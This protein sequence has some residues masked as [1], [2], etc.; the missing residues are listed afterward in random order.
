MLQRLI[1]FFLE[2]HLLTNLIFFLVLAGGAA[3]WTILKKEELPDITFDTVRIS[4]SYP[5]AAAEEVEYHVTDPL[6]EALNAIDDIYRITSSTSAGSAVITAELEQGTKNVDRV[7]SEIR[8]EVLATELPEDIRE[9][10]RIRVFKTSRKAV[11]DIGLFNEQHPLLDTVTRQQL[12]NVALELEQQLLARPEL[13]RVDRSGFLQDETHVLVNPEKL[14]ELNIP[15]NRIMNQISLHNVRQPAGSLEAPNQPKVTLYGE[16]RSPKELE[17]L[18]IQ[19]GFEGQVVRLGDIAEVRAGHAE[20][21]SLLK[22]NGREGI[23]LKVTKS[24]STGILEAIEAAQ[25][26]VLNFRK[27]LPDDSPIQ[28]VTLDDESSDLRNR[29]S[30]IGINGA[31]GFG[32]IIFILFFFLDLRSGMWVAMGIPFSL[33]FTLTGALLIGYSINNITL[34]AVIIV[35][36][37]VVD[38]AIVVAENIKRKQSLGLPLHEAATAGTATVFLPVT[39][40]II[41][42]AAAFI[43]LMFFEGR[44]GAMVSFIPAIITLMLVGSLLESLFILPG[45]MSLQGTNKRERRGEHW[46]SLWEDQYASL[47]G[48]IL[49]YR[50]MIVIISCIACGTLLWAGA[51]GMKF[52]MFPDEETREIRLKGVVASGHSQEETA[53]ITQPLEEIIRKDLGHEVTGLRNEI[54]KSRRGSPVKDNTFRMR[55]EIVPREERSRTAD[56]LIESWQQAASGLP[57]FRKLEFS[58]SRHGQDSGSPLEILVQGNNEERRREAAEVLVG[59]MRTMPGLEHIETDQPKT[60]TEHRLTLKRNMIQRLDISPSDISRTLRAALEGTVLYEYGSSIE[61]V[62]VRFS[63]EV[64]SKTSLDQLLQLP[65]ENQR[66]YLV[67]LGSVVNVETVQRPDAITRQNRIRYTTLYADIAPSS[68]L[69]PLEAAS[70][71]EQGAMQTLKERFP[72]IS[73]E[74]A[75]EVRDSR[76]SG[77]NFLLA[78]TAVIALIFMVLVLLFN[79]FRKSLLI[80]LT[81]PFG[82]AGVILSFLMHGIDIYGFFAVIGTI[83]L[84][85]VI[86]N[87]AIIMLTRLD[88]ETAGATSFSERLEATAKAAS[89]RVRAVLLTT[90]TTVAGMLPTAYG[91]AGYDPMLSQMML[92]L[93]WGLCAGTVV[94]LLFVPCLYIMMI[95]SPSTGSRPVTVATATILLCLA[96]PLPLQATNELS[97]DEYIKLATERNRNFERILLDELPLHYQSILDLPPEDLMLAVK[98]EYRLI[99]GSNADYTDTELTLEKLF[100]STGTRISSGYASGYSNRNETSSFTLTVVQPVARNAFGHADRLLGSISSTAT[101]IARYQVAEAYEDYL[102]GVIGIYYDWYAAYR[103]LET[104]RAAY[105]ETGKLLDNIREK[106]RYHIALP[107][108]VNK[109]RIQALGRRETVLEMQNKY[110][111]LSDLVAEAIR[112]EG[113][114]PYL[115]VA[116]DGRNALKTPSSLQAE[117]ATFR[118][119]SRTASILALLEQKAGLSE[120]ESARKLLPSINLR[121]GFSSTGDGHLLND[122]HEELFAGAEMLWPLP[123]TQEKA[124]HEIARIRLLQTGVDNENRKL[125]LETSLRNLYRSIENQERLITVAEQKVTI[126]KA[127]VED[128]MKEYRLGR[129]EL[130]DL[131]DETNR[132][133]DH[134]LTLISRQIELEKMLIE[135][136]RL[137]D[138]LVVPRFISAPLRVQ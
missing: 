131:L 137:T 128:E 36:G 111:A 37:I 16:L 92:A 19:G 35:M 50:K 3:S 5:G 43:P 130:N 81:I 13:S 82:L 39:A 40:S 80:M 76:E 25:Q 31:I 136:Q 120:A 94:T 69:S 20:K 54:A 116:P 118:H 93:S 88:E 115:P 126:S 72:D 57:G 124:E 104:A 17:D 79:S 87:D 109:I 60:M 119:S 23:F 91:W 71:L 99:L 114:A 29:L 110:M 55:V 113:N 48:R 41:T 85:G 106:E 22:I 65:L 58:K 45:H 14:R 47:L 28:L 122:A 70:Q 89:T 73:L 135:W 78:V 27:T 44:F 49:P 6:E 77:R 133:E 1:R 112:D 66:G 134:R 62:A 8:Q 95:S 105:E 56:E 125:S 7:V 34:A 42:T 103:N 68:G 100:P 129:T 132:L 98:S 32:L 59:M 90:M 107:L 53:T 4:V 83:G 30:I 15:F 96:A 10:P 9:L 38:D 12:Q 51:S 97:L 138:T 63:L 117:L 2:R 64:P 67:P 127:V 121:A 21:K 61:P 86:V 18:A 74:F 46:F 102:A 101:D 52:V 26:E 123:G 24:S 11:I 84:A 75:G 108:D 33:C